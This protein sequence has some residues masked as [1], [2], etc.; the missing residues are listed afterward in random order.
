MISSAMSRIARV[1][2]RHFETIMPASRQADTSFSGRSA[3]VNHAG[4]PEIG[5]ICQYFAIHAIRPEMLFPG[6]L[7]SGGIRS[8]TAHALIRNGKE[9]SAFLGP[10]R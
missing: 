2:R 4:Q 6:K 10:A 7:R 9:Y 3:L 1:R 5:T 8:P